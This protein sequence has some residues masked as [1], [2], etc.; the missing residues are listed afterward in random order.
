MPYPKIFS[1]YH[2][3]Y[4]WSR[5]AACKHLHWACTLPWKREATFL[6]SVSTALMVGYFTVFNFAAHAVRDLVDTCTTRLEVEFENAEM[7]FLPEVM[8]RSL[9]ECVAHALLDKN[10]MLRLAM[11]NKHMLD[12][13]DLEPVTEKDEE[14]CINA[15]WQPN[16]ELAKRPP[17]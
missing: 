4:E 6:L 8:P 17:L 13:T 11:L 3:V 10:G 16:V 15:L 12:P 7:D 1:R 5:E 9:C 2:A 14:A